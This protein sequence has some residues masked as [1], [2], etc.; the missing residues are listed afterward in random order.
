VTFTF[1]D[2]GTASYTNVTVY[3][4]PMNTVSTGGVTRAVSA[5][6]YSAIDVDLS[7]NPIALYQAGNKVRLAR[8]TATNPTFASQWVLQE[9]GWTGGLYVSMKIDTY[10]V[11]HAVFK[12]GSALKYG[13]AVKNGDGSYTFSPAVTIDTSG[14]LT[15]STLSF[16]RNAATGATSDTPCITYL[17][18]ESSEDGLKY[19]FWDTANSRWDFEVIPAVYSGATSYFVSPGNRVYVAGNPGTWTETQ[20]GVS[21]ASCDAVV[22]FK[23]TRVDVV[24]H[25]KE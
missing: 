12:D 17:N 20:G 15:Q 6:A 3:A 16:V 2:A 21:M 4:G 14:S 18:S 19:A 8:A 24:F 25:K 13:K 23:S 10:G 7:G 22:S 1:D 11:L 5:G 9:T